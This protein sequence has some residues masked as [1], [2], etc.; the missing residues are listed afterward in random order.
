[1][2]FNNMAYLMCWD[3]AG[4]ANKTHLARAAN[5]R[6]RSWQKSRNFVLMKVSASTT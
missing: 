1:M 6:D 5:S 4:F 2:E 3:I